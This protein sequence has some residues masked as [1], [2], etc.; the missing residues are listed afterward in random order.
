[1]SAQKVNL[2]HE[3]VKQA[4]QIQEKM[5]TLFVEKEKLNVMN[6]TQLE[7]NFSEHFSQETMRQFAYEGISIQKN[8][9][10][11]LHQ[12][13]DVSFASIYVSSLLLAGIVLIGGMIIAALTAYLLA[14]ENKRR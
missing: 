3:S 14:P 11:H 4:G 10:I 2:L 1:M 7:G 13:V 5:S 9:D 12:I 8:S 6:M